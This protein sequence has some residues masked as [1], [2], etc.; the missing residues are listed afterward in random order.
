[1]TNTC[2][3]L[4]PGYS[5]FSYADFK[6]LKGIVFDDTLA[7]AYMLD[8]KELSRTEEEIV[9]DTLVWS[10]ARNNKQR[11]HYNGHITLRRNLPPA[12]I[13]ADLDLSET[14]VMSGEQ[15]YADGIMFHGPC[16]QGVKRVLNFSYERMAMECH[17]PSITDL[18][19]GQFPPQTFNPFL[20]DIQFQCMLVWVRHFY[21]AGGL[22][23]RATLVEH[24][25]TIPLDEL[26]YVSMSMQESNESKLI[27]NIT[28]HDKNGAI[29]TRVSEAGVT[30]S[31][32]LINLF[33]QSRLSVAQQRS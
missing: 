14:H 13:F 31:K 6:V 3:Q 15:L 2:E 8:L 18:Q 28:I 12:P 30:I 19:Y 33:A 4:Y 27:A 17:A 11:Y 5:F 26:F 22:P 32:R 9:L 24:F 23:L 16:F 10:E 25:R 29:Y 1:M 20:A 21:E 7:D